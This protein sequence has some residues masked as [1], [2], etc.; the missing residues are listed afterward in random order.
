MA[1]QKGPP[2]A[3]LHP[4]VARKLLDLLSSDDDFRD[5]FQRDAHAALVQAGYQ[6]PAGIDSTTAASLSGGNCMQLEPHVTLASKEQIQA[7]RTKLEKSMSLIQGF[8]P[9]AELKA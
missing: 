7:S 2:P 3:P 5:L 9:L 1:N 6:A 8:E 4:H